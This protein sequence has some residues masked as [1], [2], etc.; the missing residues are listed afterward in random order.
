MRV[1]FPVFFPEPPPPP[2]LSCYCLSLFMASSKNMTF[3]S[4]LARWG[5]PSGRL[6][7]FLPGLPSASVAVIVGLRGPYRFHGSGNTTD[8][9]SEICSEWTTSTARSHSP[10]PR[11]GC[12]PSVSTTV[13]VDSQ[14]Q[15]PLLSPHSATSSETDSPLLWTSDHRPGLHT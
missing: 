8:T 12:H 14:F 11:N 2:F 7:P 4:S 13:P 1:A 3:K 10:F 9:T 5:I 6:Q 15:K